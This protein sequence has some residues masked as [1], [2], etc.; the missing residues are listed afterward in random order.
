M[1]LAANNFNEYEDIVLT[2]DKPEGMVRI[3]AWFQADR[4][5]R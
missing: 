5:E 2:G 4:E 1:M 3:V